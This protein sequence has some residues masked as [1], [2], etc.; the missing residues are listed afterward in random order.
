MSEAT[1]LTERNRA[2]V[3]GMFA[4]ANKGDIEGVFSYLS[5]DV[6]VIEPHFMPFG[7]TYYGKEGFYELAQI[8]PN[9]L[10]VSSITVHYTLADGDRV[11]ACIGIADIATGKLTHFIEQFTVKDGKIIENRLFY[12]DAGTLV[13]K[14]KVV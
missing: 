14:P 2:V 12:N 10:D 6:T 9:Y 7:K 11:A 5:D 8:L 1:S 3:E 4:A 13:D